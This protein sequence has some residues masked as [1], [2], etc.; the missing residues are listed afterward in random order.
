MKTTSQVCAV[1]TGGTLDPEEEDANK[2]SQNNAGATLPASA[3][4]K[5]HGGAQVLFAMRW[6]AA[7][8]MPIRPL[9]TL[10][11]DVDIPEGYTL[12]LT[13]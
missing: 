10:I 2:G 8:L 13:K 7:G 11:A 9:L 3:W 12:R 5:L 1:L 6:V 4:Q